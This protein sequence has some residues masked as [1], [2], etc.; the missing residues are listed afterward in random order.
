MHKLYVPLSHEALEQLCERASFER[1]RPQ[2]EAAVL[3]EQ[4]LVSQQR[5]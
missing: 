5:R 4:A 1:R 3:L 2:D